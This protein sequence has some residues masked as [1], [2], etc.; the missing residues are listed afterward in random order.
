LSVVAYDVGSTQYARLFINGVFIEQ[1]S[2]TR[3]SQPDDQATVLGH[4]EWYP[5]NFANSYSNS[6]FY[7]PIYFAYSGRNEVWSDADVLSL[8]SDPYQFLIPA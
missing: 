8:H 4:A 3:D 6:F 2:G 1:L 7:G 5:W